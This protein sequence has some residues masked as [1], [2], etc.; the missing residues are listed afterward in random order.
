MSKKNDFFKE[1]LRVCTSNLLI[2]LSGV[3]VG[4]I[5]PKVLGVTQYG[6]YKTFTLYAS[7]I[8][9]MS[10]GISEGMYLKYS[11]TEYDDLEVGKIRLLTKHVFR[12]QLIAAVIIC[13]VASLFLEGEKTFIF[14]AIAIYLI[15]L[16]HTTYYQ[17]VSQMTMRFND[18]SMR[19][20]VK[21]VLTIGFVILFYIAY[22]MNDKTDIS[23]RYY[24]FSV[25]LI[26]TLLWILYALKYRNL[27]FGNSSKLREEKEEIIGLMRLGIPYLIAS[28]CSTLILSIDRQFVSILFTTEEYSMYAFAYNM[29]SLVTVCASAIS[30][31]LYPS[32]KQSASSKEEITKQLS[33]LCGNVLCFAFFMLLAYYPL[34]FIVIYFLS[35]YVDSLQIFRIIFPG[36]AI[37]SVISVVI[38]NYYKLVEKNTLC[39]IKNIIILII[40]G[41]AN[42]V[43]YKLAGTT[44]S[45]SVA[46]IV[47]ILFYYIFAQEYFVREYRIKWKKNLMYALIMMLIFYSVT[48]IENYIIGFLIY[49]GAFMVITIVLYGKELKLLLKKIRR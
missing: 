46:S 6:Y 4:F 31:V 42:F 26:S 15:E 25:L 43:A 10:L 30:T 37:T 9:V 41:V 45:I 36:V 49:T 20:I 2:V 39:L 40:S 29:L 23:Y 8:G 44:A 38:Q 13:I 7:Y 12:I 47:T 48:A 32:L 3:F 33:I 17:Y 35:Q 19:N 34:S 14:F 27:T 16:N 18:Y 22:L 28:L 11:G 1:I 21:S 24:V 5:I